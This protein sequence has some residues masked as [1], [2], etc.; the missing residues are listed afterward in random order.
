MIAACTAGAAEA[1]AELTLTDTE[2]EHSSILR[3]LLD[4]AYSKPLDNFDLIACKTIL[5][6][7]RL[8]IKLDC[9]TPLRMISLLVTQPLASKSSSLNRFYYACALDDV[10]TA[11]RFIPAA[12]LQR[13]PGR[14]PTGASSTDVPF[15]GESCLDVCAMSE[16]WINQLPRKYLL[17]LTRAP[18][19]R[20]ITP[21]A[22]GIWDTVAG[23]FRAIVKLQSA[24][25]GGS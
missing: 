7:I 23:E 25:D 9:A 15:A 11:Y 21:Y 5:S 8:A 3:L 20:M 6:L 13:Y 24:S 4:L 18:R 22:P 17:A 12:A 10:E 2:L 1:A 14:A 16:E 19:W